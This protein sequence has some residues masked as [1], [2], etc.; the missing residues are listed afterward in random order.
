V[1][2]PCPDYVG[3]V[4]VAAAFCPAPPVLVPDVASGAAAE[5]DDLRSAAL[6]AINALGAANPDLLVL[7][8][9]GP[10]GE[11]PSGSRGTLAGFGVDLTASLG[12]SDSVAASGESEPT[13]MPASLT[14]GAWMVAQGGW[15]GPVT[16]MSV[17]DDLRADDAAERGER[18]AA[19][20]PRVAMLVLGESSARLEA[21]APGGF[22]PQAPVMHTVVR[23]A[24]ATIDTDTL[25]GLDP[26]RATHL[27]VSGR[28]TWQVAAGAARA[29]AS[30]GDREGVPRGLRGELRVDEA[31][32]G[33]GYLVVSWSPR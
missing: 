11:F 23:D 7:V 19:Q 4:L 16:A 1:L 31:P 29:A 6:A 25:L 33:V 18:W 28:V 17:P 24:L 32:Y 27:M 22:D 26:A 5:L 8:G 12:P 30:S 2:P 10:E 9:E 13:R 21:R 20:A 15:S 14:V 3:P